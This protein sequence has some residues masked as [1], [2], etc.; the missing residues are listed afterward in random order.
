MEEDADELEQNWKTLAEITSALAGRARFPRTAL[1][2]KDPEANAG[3]PTSGLH[4]AAWLGRED[5]RDAKEVAGSLS[6]PVPGE[7]LATETTCRA[8]EDNPTHRIGP[9]PR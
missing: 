1:E 6:D 7:G 9:E 4:R 5:G 8:G 3:P 2:G